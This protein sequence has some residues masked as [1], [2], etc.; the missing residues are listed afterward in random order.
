M[1][2]PGERRLARLIKRQRRNWPVDIAQ[3]RVTTFVL[4]YFLSIDTAAQEYD[5]RPLFDARR[6]N[7]VH[8]Y[9]AGL[10]AVAGKHQLTLC[11]WALYRIFRTSGRES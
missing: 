2:P 10:A 11:G 9:G 4:R 7:R 3:P 6:A 8:G 5:T 1:V